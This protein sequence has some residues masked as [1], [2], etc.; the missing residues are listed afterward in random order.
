M[1]LIELARKLRPII[2]KAAQSLADEDAVSCVELFPHWKPRV[3]FSETDV[4]T[5]VMYGGLL[6]KVRSP[7][8]T[9]ADWTPDITPALYEGVSLDSEAGT[10]DNPILYNGNMTLENGKYYTQDDVLYLCTR[11]SGNPVYH[12]LKDLVGLYVAVV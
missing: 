7:H 1:S 12:A 11:D 3:T 4:G 5:R 8:T 10:K 9:Q 6:Y 2:E